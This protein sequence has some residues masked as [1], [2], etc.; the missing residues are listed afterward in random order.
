LCDFLLRRR[1]CGHSKKGC[2]YKKVWDYCCFHDRQPQ[3]EAVYVTGSISNRSHRCAL[4]NRQTCI[5]KQRRLPNQSSSGTRF[6]HTN[7]T[8]VIRFTSYFA[9]APQRQRGSSIFQSLGCSSDSITCCRRLSRLEGSAISRRVDE[10][11]F[12]RPD[13]KWKHHQ[14]QIHDYYGYIPGSCQRRARF[15]DSQAQCSSSGQRSA[16]VV[17]FRWPPHPYQELRILHLKAHVIAPNRKLRRTESG[18]MKCIVIQFL[19]SPM[20][21]FVSENGTGRV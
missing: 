17:V 7:S 12:A 18:K 11:K 10:V 6:A 15:R 2:G 14:R 21:M 8:L 9:S 3:F 13:F 4:V 19:V 1:A 16:G 20:R 5:R